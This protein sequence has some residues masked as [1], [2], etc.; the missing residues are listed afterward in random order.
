METKTKKR[1]KNLIQKAY[2]DKFG[3]IPLLTISQERQSPL[4]RYGDEEHYN[5]DAKSQYLEDDQDYCP[6]TAHAV[7]YWK[8][9]VEEED[10]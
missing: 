6:H 5:K 2:E 4:D 3:L 10:F 1:P 7:F 9:W 8:I